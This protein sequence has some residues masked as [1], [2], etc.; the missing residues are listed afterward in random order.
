MRLGQNPAK[1]GLLAY[2]PA[3]LGIMLVTYIPTLSGYFSDSLEIF[4][5]QLASLHKNTPTDFNILVFDNGSCQE[6]QD[7]LQKLQSDGLIDW[8]T[9]S[10]HNLG[11]TGALNW[12]IRAMPNEIICYSDGDVYFRSGW[13]EHSL[14]ILETF[15][16]CGMVTAQPCYFDSLAGKGKAYISLEELK[17]IEVSSRLADVA[18]TEEYVRSIGDNPELR[19]RYANH[20]WQIVRNPIKNVEAVIG[21]SHFQFLAQKSLLEQ[22]TPF[23]SIHGLNREDDYQII[24]RIDQ[25]GFMQLSTEKPYVYHMGNKIDMTTLGEIQRDRLNDILNNHLAVSEKANQNQYSP[26]KK[27]AFWIL[28]QMTRIPVLRRIF[29][30][31]YNLLFEYYASVK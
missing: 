29:Q 16:R 9:L 13:Y 5:T 15:P 30:R 11:K 21:A 2:H 26:A 7:A 3:Q 1:N 20:E 22:I 28:H 25:M 10:R 24:S 27:T 31:F 17:Q 12:G 4:K 14:N 23:P 19:T 18:A 8:L 6:I